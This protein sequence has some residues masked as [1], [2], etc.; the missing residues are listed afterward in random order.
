M[1]F[2]QENVIGI[3]NPKTGRIV[4]KGK[5]CNKIIESAL[6]I[7]FMDNCIV[8]LAQPK[9]MGK[10]FETILTNDWINFVMIE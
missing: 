2:Q 3:F 10:S 6:E 4:I 8:V 1:K 7:D 9:F 5:F